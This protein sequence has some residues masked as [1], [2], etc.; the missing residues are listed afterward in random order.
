MAGQAI[1]HRG[2]VPISRALRTFYAEMATCTADV[3]G[4]MDRVIELEVGRAHRHALDAVAVRWLIA[5][6]AERTGSGRLRLC[7]RHPG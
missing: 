5:D 2:E 6:M 7:A 3:S 4:R 1:A